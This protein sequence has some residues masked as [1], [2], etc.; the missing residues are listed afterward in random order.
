MER[1]I[2]NNHSREL[3]YFSELS[4]K[5]KKKVRCE[6]STIENLDDFKFFRYQNVWYSLEDFLRPSD[7]FMGWD[8]YYTLLIGL[9]IVIKL[10]TS[11]EY[12]TVGRMIFD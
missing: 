3:L 1:V 5:D 2:T 12:V 9:A 7:D 4:D 8:G 11:G 6:Y 10:S